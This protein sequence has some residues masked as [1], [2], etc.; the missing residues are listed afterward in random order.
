MVRAMMVVVLVVLGAASAAAA[1][2]LVVG[3]NDSGSFPYI[4]GRGGALRS[5]PGLSVE[6]VQEAA[7]RLDIDVSFVRLPGLR[8][9]LALKE[10]RIDA[11]LL[12]S[13]SRDR[14]AYGAYPMLDGKPDPAR[15]LATLSYVLY[16]PT[17]SSLDWNG[18]AFVNLTGQIAANLNYSIVGTL[19]RLRVPVIEARSTADSF[20]ML[21]LHRVVGIVD[22]EVVADA[23][24]AAQG[25]A[26]VE[27]VETPLRRKPYYLMLSHQYVAARPD[28]A[29]AIWDMLGT[30]RDPLTQAGSV[31]Y[32]TEPPDSQ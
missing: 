27:K 7:R 6:L 3:L 4:V 26:G 15:R 23:H 8:V 17:G 31:N 21:Q 12:F 11:A 25:L 5:P 10:G 32:Q 29:R 18:A 1:E 28:R 14:E 24:I 20:R 30:L 16:R 9:L 13:Y 2:R 22:Q 19:R